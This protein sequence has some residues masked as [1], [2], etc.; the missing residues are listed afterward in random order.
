MAKEAALAKYEEAKKDPTE[1]QVHTLASEAD[2]VINTELSTEEDVF[3]RVA[4]FLKLL[5]PTN[6][7]SVDVLIGGQFGSEGKGH[8]AAHIAPDYDCLV[9]VGGPNAGQPT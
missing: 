2:L 5:P 1:N 4:G 9:R 6:S 3:I 8:V 7:E